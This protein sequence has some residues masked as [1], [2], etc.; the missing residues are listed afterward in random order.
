MIFTEEM[1]KDLVEDN[2]KGIIQICDLRIANK[3]LTGIIYKDLNGEKV[4]LQKTKDEEDVLSMF[5]NIMII[6]RV[7]YIK[8]LGKFKSYVSS[9]LYNKICEDFGTSYR[10]VDTDTKTLTL[11]LAICRDGKI[12]NTTHSCQLQKIYLSVSA[13]SSYIE[14]ISELRSFIGKGTTKQKPRVNPNTAIS[15]AEYRKRLGYPLDNEGN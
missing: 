9:K 2:K 4:V 7:K 1:Y 10:I 14:N 3:Q 12:D 8:G 15:Y 13:Q 6:N 5:F 11:T